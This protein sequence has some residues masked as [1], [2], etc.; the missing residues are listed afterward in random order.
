[1]QIP[2]GAIIQVSTFIFMVVVGLGLTR[3][4]F[5]RVAQ[6]PGVVVGAIAGQWLLLPAVAWILILTLPLPPTIAIGVALLASCPAGAI[7]TYYSLIARADVALSMTLTAVSIA[8][9]TLKMPLVSSISFRLL[10]D[11]SI[12]IE[13]PV[14]PMVIQLLLLLALPTALGMGLRERHRD[15]VL[16]HMNAAR[17]VGDVTIVITTVIV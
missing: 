9:A 10:L 12:R 1:V 16:R 7:S 2:L 15:T 5:R 11:E 8:I 13:V 4:D 14:V 6:H 3:N 17:R